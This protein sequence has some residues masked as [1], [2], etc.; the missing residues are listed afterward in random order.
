MPEKMRITGGERVS[1]M[2]AVSTVPKS[3]GDAL[4][5]RV[6]SRGDCAWFQLEN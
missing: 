3:M 1:Q 2:I 4:R 5:R 6:G